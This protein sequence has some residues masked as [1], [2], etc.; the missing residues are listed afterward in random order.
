MKF[1]ARILEATLKSWGAAIAILSLASSS[2]LYFYIPNTDTVKLNIFSVVI[3]AMFFVIIILLRALY[4]A[5]R[6]SGIKLP[7][8]RKILG[9]PESYKKAS[10]L[11]LANPS[12]LLSHDS[13]VSVFIL[14]EDYE[15]LIGIGIV[16]NIQD[17]KKIAIALFTED[18]LEQLVE[19][20]KKNKKHLLDSLL[21]K[22]SV[23]RIFLRGDL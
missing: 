7:R 12:T 1:S 6:E 21:L 23:P 19:D 2:L 20:L 11:L 4:E 3:F 17:D 5:T 18:G 9:S 14:E 8:V 15:K 13:C 10:A 16:I 22:P